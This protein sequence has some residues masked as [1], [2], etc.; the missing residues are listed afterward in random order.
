LKTTMRHE[1]I[2]AAVAS[3]RADFYEATVG[4]VCR[5]NGSGSV[6]PGGELPFTG[7][8]KVLNDFA[9][10]DFCRRPR[11]E[12]LG[13]RSRREAPWSRSYLHVHGT[14]SRPRGGGEEPAMLVNGDRETEE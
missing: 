14:G 11:P 13:T 1:P 6:C 4:A 2:F 5:P 3:Q 7:G 8:A 12:A 10:A 9:E